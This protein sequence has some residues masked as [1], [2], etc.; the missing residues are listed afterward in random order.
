[1]ER[2]LDKEQM[3]ELL[4]ESIVGS[5]FFVELSSEDCAK[6]NLLYMKE[7]A[8][9]SL[10]LT[11]KENDSDTES[12]D[13]YKRL[14]KE[15]SYVLGEKIAVIVDCLEKTIGKEFIPIL[16]QPCYN[17]GYDGRMSKI[18]I[19]KICPRRKIPLTI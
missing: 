12:S 2:C 19:K 15:Y 17:I 5:E 4:Q 8:L 16:S 6:L 3:M 13:L 9:N 10:C 1:M 7:T 11:L 18:Y 14:V